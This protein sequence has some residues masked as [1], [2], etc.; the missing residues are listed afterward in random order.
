MEL[1][2][3]K[4]FELN[5]NPSNPHAGAIQTIKQSPYNNGYVATCSWDKTVKIWNPLNWILIKTFMGHS[6]MVYSAEF[7]NADI[8]ATSDS[9]G[10]ILIWSISSGVINMTINAGQY[11]SVNCLKLLSNGNYLAAG[12]NSTI[13]IYNI[14]TGILILSLIGHTST[15][16]DLELITGNGN[17]LLAS[18]SSDKT[19]RIWDLN[20]NMTKFVLTG[21]NDLVTGLKLLSSDTLASG[22]YDTTI[23][24]WSLTTGTLIRT[25]TGHTS[26]IGNSIDLL[27]DG[28][29][30]VS[31]SWDW[32]VH[33]WNWRTGQLLSTTYYYNLNIQSLAVVKLNPIS[34]N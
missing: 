33:L 34:S 22:S 21:H 19:I 31:G 11:N 32:R 24:I 26:Y 30:L 18:S 12:L 7:I 14:N 29:T 6:S 1:Y 23:K 16:N 10:I 3:Q 9:T 27:S 2:D 13:N 17:N 8:I 25:L 28:Q 15:V 5:F 4:L 20:T